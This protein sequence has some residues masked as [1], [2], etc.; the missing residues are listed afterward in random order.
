MFA[1]NLTCDGVEN[2]LFIPEWAGLELCK[3]LLIG[4]A[5]ALSF[6][7]ILVS[8]LQTNIL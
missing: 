2:G 4:G 6:P 8:S 1:V 5:P 7:L 3:R